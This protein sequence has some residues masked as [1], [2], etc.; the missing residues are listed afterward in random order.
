M[1]YLIK[2]NVKENIEKINNSNN[3]LKVHLENGKLKKI[4]V[5]IHT[6]SFHFAGVTNI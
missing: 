3:N 6:Y 5:Y 4:N 2:R 1:H